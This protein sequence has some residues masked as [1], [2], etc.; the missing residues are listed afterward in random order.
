[1][2]ELV[3]EKG[4][5]EHEESFKLSAWSTSLIPALGLNTAAYGVATAAPNP[6]SRAHVSSVFNPG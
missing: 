2:E 5:T 6:A 4:N 1:M 3:V